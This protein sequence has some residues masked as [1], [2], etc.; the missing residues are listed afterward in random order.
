[1]KRILIIEDNDDLAFGL[2]NNLEIEGYDVIAAAT[3][4]AGLERARENRPDLILL[5]LMLPEMDGFQLLR[6]LKENPRLREIPILVLTAKELSGA[7]REFLTRE[8]CAFFSKEADWKESLTARLRE[9]LKSTA[10]S[11]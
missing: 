10:R 5:D 4:T 9:V 11:P 8:T 6:R 2:R 7:D 3:G 1:M